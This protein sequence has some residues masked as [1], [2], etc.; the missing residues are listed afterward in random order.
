MSPP[1]APVAVVFDNDGLLLDTESVWTRAEQQLYERRGRE[2]TLEQKQE[3]VGTSAQIAGGILARRLEEPGRDTEIIEE[4]NGL[5]MAELENGVD[6][7]VG[8]RE[9]IAALDEAGTPLGLVSNS[10]RLFI[11]RALAIADLEGC[12]AA[13]VSGH[14]VGA[15]K[16]A[17]DPYLEACR[18][19]AVEPGPEVVALEDSPTGV[20]A[21][22]AAGLRVVG[23]PSL[24][25]IDLSDAHLQAGSLEDGRVLTAVGL[26]ADGGPGG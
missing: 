13:V 24:P 17:P 25:G 1:A 11:E 3:L 7:M 8:A 26:Q 16:P 9:L 2:F 12:F 4:L 23:I 15:P 19:L 10:P 20:A 14:E 6:P 18:L 22:V 5:V 21:A